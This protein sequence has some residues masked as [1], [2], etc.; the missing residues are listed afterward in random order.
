MK[1]GETPPGQRPGN[2]F[3]RFGAVG[4]TPIPDLDK[5]VALRLSGDVLSSDVEDGQQVLLSDLEALPRKTQV[6]DLHCV[7]TWTKPHL[8]WS[9]WSLREV[10]EL[11]LR[12]RC[13]A[14][15]DIRFLVFHGLDRYRATL[16]LEDALA[17]D[18]LIADRLDGEPLSAVHGAPLRLVSP[19]QYGYKSV[20][21][22]SGIGLR[23]EPPTGGLR[24]GLEHPRGRVEHQERHAFLPPWLVRWPY[25]ALIGLTALRLR[26]GLTS[27]AWVSEPTLLDEIMPSFEENEVHDVY[28]DADPDDVEK[29]LKA[30]TGRELRMLGPL[31]VLRELPGWLMGRRQKSEGQRERNRPLFDD[32]VQA[33]FVQLDERPGREIVFGVIGRFWSLAGNKPIPFDG[34]EEFCDWDRPD[35]ALAVMNFLIRREGT[36]SRLLTETRIRTTDAASRRK[37]KLYWRIIRWGSGAIRRSWLAAVRRRCAATR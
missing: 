28:L 16:D 10:W 33:G 30:V 3:P 18:L 12:P 35:N 29:A 17:D 27:S 36:G 2:V 37:F 6:S 25:R 34:R 8:E 5:P 4:G 15:D 31:V 14:P 7:T 24:F 32:L 20:K 21:H 11:L 23:R 13:D 9:G 1:A 22:L 19:W 26:R